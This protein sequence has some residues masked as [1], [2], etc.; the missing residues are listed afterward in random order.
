MEAWG[1]ALVS[2]GAT[3][4]GAVLNHWLSIDRVKRERKAAAQ[5]RLREQSFSVLGRLRRWLTEANPDSLGI[6]ANKETSPEVF[7]NLHRRCDEIRDELGVLSVGL[8][9]ERGRDLAGNP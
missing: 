7:A 3:L 6:N 8:P 4:A 5:E 2:V 1:I 9:S